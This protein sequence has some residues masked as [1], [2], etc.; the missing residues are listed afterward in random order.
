MIVLVLGGARSGKSELA[1]GLVARLATAGGDVAVTYLATGWR[2]DGTDPAWAARVAAHRL[3]RPTGWRTVEVGADLA[4]ALA[5]A[6]DGPVLVDSLGAWVAGAGD[7]F[8]VDIAA[9]GDALRARQPAVTVLVSDEAGLGVTP[10]TPVGNAFRDALG[11]V[12]RAVSMVADEA[13][14]V[15]AGRKLRLEA[16]DA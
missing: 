1:E 15:V 7:S 2:P 11:E 3:R 13:W 14:L 6:G 8:D 16:P 10:S 5:D 12:N 4:A 9:V